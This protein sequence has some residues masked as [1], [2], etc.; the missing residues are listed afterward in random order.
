METICNK[1]KVKVIKDEKFKFVTI[2]LSFLNNL[3]YE[4]IAAYNLLVRLLTTRNNKYQSTDTFSSYLENNYGMVIGGGY[5]NRGNVSIFNIVSTSMN[6]KYAINENL[7][8]SQIELI[9]DCLFDPYINEETLKEAKT[10][11]IQKLKE[12]SN[13]KTYILKKKVHKLMDNNSPYG[14]DIESDINEIEKV[15]LNKISEVYN[16]LINS[17]CYAYICGDI[18]ESEAESLFKDINFKNNDNHFLNLSYLK[19]LEKVD[20]QVFESHYLQSAVSIIYQ[21]DINYDDKLYYALKL[22]LEMFNYDLF[23]II[24]EKYNF[25]YYIYAISNNYL[26]TIEI[27][28]EIESKN[29]D[30]MS[31]IIETIIK[32]YNDNFN[33]NQ[34]EVSKAKILNYIKNSYDSGA[35][36]IDIHFGFDFNK[37]ISSIEELEDKYKNVTIDEVKEVSTMLSL[38]M[39]SL[40]KEGSKHE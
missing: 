18:N 4:D 29:L 22:F 40:L 39:I 3:V 33:V 2:R 36:L 17:D 34:F 24:R 19:N 9:K 30:R 27:V 5:F 16:K 21:C 7:L 25:C 1:F 14:V 20:T 28:S 35:D 37:T 32:D 15:D 13:K 26:N 8:L 31:E 12:Q 6:S 23:N 10:I 11:Y 38:K